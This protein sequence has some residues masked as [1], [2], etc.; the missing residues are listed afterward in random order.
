MN[1][2]L[3]TLFIFN[4]P[5]TKINFTGNKSVSKGE[6]LQEIISK[7]NNEYNNIN[8]TFDIKKILKVY[9]NYG[10]F[11]AEVTPE[12][13]ATEQAIEIIFAIEEGARPKITEIRIYGEK[14][15]ELKHLFDIKINDFFIREKIYDTKKRIENHYKDRGYPF[16]SVSS[17]MMPD[18]GI[19][20][21]AIEKGIVHYIRKINIKGLKS[22]NPDVVLREIELKTGDTF[23]KSKLYNSQREIYGLGFFSTIDVEM[24]RYEPD[25]LDLLFT[26]RELK[27]R[28][29]N[30]GVGFSI[31]VSFLFSF[32]LEELNL[33]NTGHRFK[34]RPS[35]QINIDGEWE[36][37]LEAKYTIPNI[38]PARLTLSLLPFYWY[39]DKLDFRRITIG[40]EFRV[41]KI[42]NENIQYNIAHRYKSVDFRPKVTQPDTLRGV[43]NSIKLQ[44][45]VDYREEFFNPKKGI[46]LLP[47]IEYAGGIFGGDNNFLRLEVEERL[48][49]PLLKHTIA[50]RLKLGV[51]I[52]TDGLAVSEKYYLGG[53][54]SLRGYPERSVGPDLF[55]EERYGKILANFNIEYRISLPLNFGLVAFF[56]VGFVDNEINF[57]RSEFLKASTGFGLRYYTLIGPLRCDIGYPFPLTKD[58]WEIY[59]GI[60]HIF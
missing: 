27:S 51:M 6:L 56:D 20:D 41:S 50:Q 49:L 1:S 5:I 30:F 35:F 47:L 59:L 10:F 39:E 57:T 54:Y 9:K 23:N 58:N 36:S 7:K 25:T 16:A 44:F 11:A 14:R 13:N 40:N 2:L 22:C 4:V 42:Y 31:P 38:T 12:V 28:I 26:V 29:L 53:Q 48:F 8:L 37:K 43:T 33:F 45:M 21:L 15:E 34:I 18:S 24:L 19:L 60:Y 55:F 32:T 46:Y 3:I 17:S 52:P